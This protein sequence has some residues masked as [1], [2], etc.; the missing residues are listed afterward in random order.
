MCELLIIAKDALSR[1]EKAEL[2]AL[3]PHLQTF[4]F[5][6]LDYRNKNYRTKDLND[7]EQVEKCAINVIIAFVPKLSEIT[8]RPFFYK[9]SCILK[10]QILFFAS[11]IS[12][13]R[14]GN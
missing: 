1:G 6:A 12:A 10:F 7:I 4:I 8:F 9:V 11:T 13:S 5:K 2:E 14:L 3:M